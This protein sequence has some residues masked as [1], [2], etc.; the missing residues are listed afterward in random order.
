MAS[1][2]T[3]AI[4]AIKSLQLNSVHI[5]RPPCLG[6]PVPSASEDRSHGLLCSWSSAMAF[7]G[8]W[9]SRKWKAETGGEQHMHCLQRDETLGLLSH[10]FSFG[11]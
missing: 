1:K 8:P 6:K 5:C 11:A 10:V 2:N 3:C 7:H 9:S 4:G